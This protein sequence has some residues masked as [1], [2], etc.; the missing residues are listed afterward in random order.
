MQI[1]HNIFNSE[2]NDKSVIYCL[3]A[4]MNCS[5]NFTRIEFDLHSI[6]LQTYDS[7]DVKLERNAE[8]N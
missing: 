7:R 3:V 1:L 6:A 8:I 4:P 2:K 5:K